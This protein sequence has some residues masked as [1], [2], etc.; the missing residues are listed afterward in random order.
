MRGDS[1]LLAH[2]R[3]SLAAAY[4]VDEVDD[5]TVRS[6][7]RVL[8]VGVLELD[9]GQGDRRAPEL[10]L[11]DLLV[12]RE[13]R[14]GAFDELASDAFRL[15]IHRAWARAIDVRAFLR[16]R[17]F[18][19]RDDPRY[20]AAIDRL[21]TATADLL[22]AQVEELVIEAP[23]GMVRIDRSV[24]DLLAGASSAIALTGDAGSG[25][26]AAAVNLAISLREY[27]RDVVFL[28]ADSFRADVAAVRGLDFTEPLAEVF[29]N[30][31]GDGEATLVVDG[32]DSARGTSN[33]GWVLAL[34]P[35]LEGTRWRTI[36][37]FRTYDLRNGLEWRRAFRGEAVDS[38]TAITDLGDVHHLLVGD[39]ADV[40]LDQIRTQT[41]VTEFVGI[42]GGLA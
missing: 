31:D 40:E 22:D 19:L 2:T 5:D 41:G 23:E 29:L 25:K 6:F 33:D 26:S 42:F 9:S 14:Y 1:A 34:L 13:R 10:L 17:D 37:T 36:A 4:G 11:G 27:G 30:W 20:A 16:S 21:R 39:L 3:R 15:H 7:F 8:F 28:T 12:D 24:A 18:V 35:K 32:L 38:P